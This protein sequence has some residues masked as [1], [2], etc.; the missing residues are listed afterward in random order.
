MAG[1]GAIARHLPPGSPATV[2]CLSCL[3]NKTDTL[4]THVKQNEGKPSEEGI[5][6]KGSD[7]PKTSPV[8][9]VGAAQR[10]QILLLHLV[11]LVDIQVPSVT[12]FAVLKLLNILYVI[13]HVSSF[14]TLS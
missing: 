3:V 14:R 10:L 5:L 7:Q 12:R 9:E 6:G 4:Y 8:E 11:L 1:A 13:G 2:Y